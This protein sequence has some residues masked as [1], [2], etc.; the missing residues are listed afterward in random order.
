MLFTVLLTDVKMSCFREQFT[1]KNKMEFELVFFMLSTKIFS[2]KSF[3]EIC[4]HI[5]SLPLCFC[6]F[7]FSIFCVVGMHSFNLHNLILLQSGDIEMNPGSM[8][9]SRLNSCHCNVNGIAAY[10]FVK[11]TLIDAFIQANIFTFNNPT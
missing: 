11:V 2:N 9:F 5:F 6:L 4:S 7:S 3:F 1:S 8:N 10:D